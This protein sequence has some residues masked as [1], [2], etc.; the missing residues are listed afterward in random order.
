MTFVTRLPAP[1]CGS[2]L[3]ISI[4]EPAAGVLFL[5]FAYELCGSREPLDA[6]EAAALR[7]A[8][9][10]ADLDFVRRLRELALA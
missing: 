5:R 10:H 3:R 4:D 6:R 2:T 9:H 7:D 1:F 8:Y